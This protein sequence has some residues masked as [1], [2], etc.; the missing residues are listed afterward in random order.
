M[1]DEAS[2]LDV[3]KEQIALP[4]HYDDFKQVTYRDNTAI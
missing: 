2:K 1:S 4:K 3:I